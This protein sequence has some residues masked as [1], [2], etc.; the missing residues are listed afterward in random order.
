MAIGQIKRFAQGLMVSTGSPAGSAFYTGA[1]DIIGVLRDLAICNY[2][3]N[4]RSYSVYF[5]PSGGS[6]ANANCIMKDRAI[7]AGASDMFRFIAPL[8]TGDKLWLAADAGSALSVQAS[9]TEYA[10]SQLTQ[11]TPTRLVQDVCPTSIATKYTVGAGKRAIIKDLLI[12]NLGSGTPDFD[13]AVVK[14]GE[15]LTNAAY[16][17]KDYGLTANQSLQ[18]RTSFVLEAGDTVRLNASSSNAVA[19]TMNGVEWTIPV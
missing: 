15:S 18:L 14:S 11:W 1:S 13:I 12:C 4:G 17:F 2:S 7:A 9:G 10:T 8:N 16:W 3:A 19:I 6:A 5:V